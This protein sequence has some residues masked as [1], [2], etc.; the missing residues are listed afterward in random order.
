MRQKKTMVGLCG[1]NIYV[2]VRKQLVKML[3]L[4]PMNATNDP[5]LVV[6]T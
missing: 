6:M 5:I 1:V 2:R 3:L 4:S